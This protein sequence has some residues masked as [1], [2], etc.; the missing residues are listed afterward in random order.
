LVA[1]TSALFDRP[2]LQNWKLD[3]GAWTV[4]FVPQVLA[5]LDDKKRDPRLT[6]AA[7]KV[8]RRLDDLGRRGDTPPRSNLSPPIC[9]VVSRW[10]LV[11]GTYATRDGCSA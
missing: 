9:A 1:D 10:S 3:G 2:D 6:A 8:I 4:V 7:D 5:E 11:T